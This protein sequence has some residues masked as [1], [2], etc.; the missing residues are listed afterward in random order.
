[1]KKLIILLILST[2]FL[3]AK[4]QICVSIPPQAF[5]VQKIAGNLVDIEI[6][7]KPGSNPA[8]YA[9]KPSQLKL[10]S[11]SLAYFTIGVSFE[12][13][14]L[15]RFS[16]INKEMKII[17]TTKGIKKIEMGHD[18]NHGKDHHE[19]LDPHVWLDPALVKMQITHI[20][21]TLIKL[22]P[23][24]KES[25]LTNSTNFI[26]ELESIDLKI[27][28]ILKDTKS[29]EFIVFHPSFGYFAKAYGLK[30]IAIEKEGKEAK[31]KRIKKIIDFAKEKN[32]KT[33]FV[34]PEFSQK[35]AKQIANQ[36]DGKV[37]TVNPLALDWD[38]N[39]LSIAKSLGHERE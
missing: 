18:H 15:H 25:Y 36:I 23:N 22:D 37:I 14:W 20:S 11:K 29:K 27:K 28:S 4:I 9:P 12:K 17:D 10:I 1:M 24:H 6:L 2:T 8:T 38:K 5:F 7:V 33:I 19:S 32:I 21:D 16:S 31:I 13:N 3:S 26:K 39:I 30:Q 35:S 34:A